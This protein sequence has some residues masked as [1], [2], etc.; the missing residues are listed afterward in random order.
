MMA[1]TEDDLIKRLNELK[2]NMENRGTRVNMN[3]I[4]VVISEER[5]NVMQKD[6]RWPCGVCGRGVGSN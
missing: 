1:G 2:D 6:A 5:Q 3:K 4:K